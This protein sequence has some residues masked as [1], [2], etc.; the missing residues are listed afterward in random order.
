M[1]IGDSLAPDAT[2]YDARDL[3]P[4]KTYEFVITALNSV[5]EGQ[6]S[7]PTAAIRIDPE[8]LFVWRNKES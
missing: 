8:G 1:I 2:S 6:W 3:K 7:V 5:G 4:A